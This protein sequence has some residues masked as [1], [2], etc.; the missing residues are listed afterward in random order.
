MPFLTVKYN[1]EQLSQIKSLNGK[2][3]LEMT[4]ILTE[5]RIAADVL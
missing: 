3:I 5:R 1:S 2:S 4:G